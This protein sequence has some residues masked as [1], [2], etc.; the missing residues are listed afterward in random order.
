MAEPQKK[1]E[2]E[3]VFSEDYKVDVKDLSD[4]E[5]RETSSFISNRVL[6]A[7][8]GGKQERELAQASLRL[9]FKGRT[10]M[11]EVENFIGRYDVAR[12]FKKLKKSLK[13]NPYASAAFLEKL[14]GDPNWQNTLLAILEDNTFELLEINLDI[15]PDLWNFLKIQWGQPTKIKLFLDAR[16]HWQD[17]PNVFAR[18]AEILSD[19]SDFFE[20]YRNIPSSV[21]KGSAVIL[22]GLDKYPSEPNRWKTLYD[23]VNLIR[24]TSCL[25]ILLS[26]FDVDFLVDE[27]CYQECND[28][29]E[30]NRG[31]Q[32]AL[33]AKLRFSYIKLRYPEYAELTEDERFFSRFTY[34]RNFLASVKHMLYVFKVYK[35][36]GE[37][38]ETAD[39]RVYALTSS[40]GFSHVK[41]P[42]DFEAAEPWV[43]AFHKPES[44][45]TQEYERPMKA[46]IK[47]SK[48]DPTK[49]AHYLAVFVRLSKIW[50]GG[51]GALA[52]IHKLYPFYEMDLEQLDICAAWAEGFN[53]H[54]DNDLKISE[55][56]IRI[57]KSDTA[58]AAEY[59]R[60]L[61]RSG[62]SNH[63]P[64]G[65]YTKLRRLHEVYGDDVVK[66]TVCSNWCDEVEVNSDGKE[67]EKEAVQIFIALQEEGQEK[68]EKAWREFLTKL[69]ELNGELG[70]E[71]LK[72]LA[73]SCLVSIPGQSNFPALLERTQL[74]LTCVKKTAAL[75]SDAKQEACAKWLLDSVNF[76]TIV[77]D[78]TDVDFVAQ[79]LGRNGLNTQD[80]LE[81]YAESLKAN[82]ITRK[83]RNLVLEFL[84]HFRVVSPAIISGYKTAKAGGSEVVYLAQLNSVT[85]KMTGAEK[86]T[87][88][89]RNLPYYED[90]I[91]EVYKN[92][93]GHWTDYE[94]NKSCEDKEEDIAHYQYKP[95]YTIDLFSQSEIKV[96]P[97]E[98]LDK[99]KTDQLVKSVMEVSAELGSK[100]YEPSEMKKMVERKVD[101]RFDKV[102][103]VGGREKP[104]LDTLGVEEKLCVIVL[105]AMY[106]DNK[107][108]DKELKKLLISYEF[109]YFE[110]I[111]D[112]VQ[113]TNDRVS[114]APNKEYALLCELNT[115]FSD[116]IKEINKRIIQTGFKDPKVAQ[117]VPIYFEQLSRSEM[118]R[119]RQ[120]KVEGMQP[121]K[122]GLTGA[123]IKQ[124]T[125]T[126]E[127]KSGKKYTTEEVKK[128]IA[129]Y[130]KATG[131]LPENA[132][133]STKQRTKAVYGQLRSQ[134]EKTR[135]LAEFVTGQ[136]LDPRRIHLGE[137]N[138]AELMQAEQ[139]IS[140]GAYDPI[141]FEAYTVQRA[142]NLFTEEKDFLASELD[143]FISE[144]A[145][146]EVKEEGEEGKEAKE[147]KAPIIRKREVLNAYFAK[148]KETAN[149]RMVGG[150]CVSGDN[151]KKVGKDCMWN[152]K[153]YFELV[154]EDPETHRCMGVVLLHAFEEDGK[155]LAASFNP[156]STYL[157]KVDEAALF[158][159]L[160]ETLKDFAV[161]NKFTR[162]CSSQNKAIRT[163]RTGGIFE[164]TMDEEISKVGKVYQFPEAKKFSYSPSYEIQAMDTLWEAKK[165]A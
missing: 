137:M 102:L 124:I 30:K 158:K 54:D 42:N 67:S 149:A 104:K 61:Y 89:E 5:I 35:E 120:S 129:R 99:T 2:E 28:F 7:L 50:E 47:L 34:Y 154:L 31:E 164:R 151:P 38:K 87:T 159:G 49:A 40:R 60:L 88:A 163:N 140:G 4:R 63:L 15:L 150:V 76:N 21:E 128:L 3:D 138:V 43:T 84:Q 119:Q 11:S 17:N 56:Y 12:N 36:A 45:D 70:K 19:R 9:E 78:A 20:T 91:R 29:Y 6:S 145:V 26:D 90:L 161:E 8:L 68:Y 65:H 107:T 130:E 152:M 93:V 25:E 97:G 121:A 75:F 83:D 13:G 109:A 57:Y 74:M 126:L 143:K 94:N 24:L 155:T 62:H 160:L 157:Y 141:Q 144:T 77:S 156:S 81:G 118:S 103:K 92:N 115:F 116:R 46:Y 147:K 133:S 85:G 10:K 71:N 32:G 80:I 139:N 79:V 153:N 69:R 108:D 64:R 142:L 123:F 131:G 16:S 132:S 14:E 100:E 114:R 125:K 59:R 110:D 95:R 165:A 53:I 148:N 44:M 51:G 96:K 39:Q 18:L 117:V 41:D 136:D 72:E 52:S 98:A 101:E 1:P 86:L 48:E 105:D 22:Q 55:S 106:G 82:A 162:I 27:N 135:Q 73:H 37:D 127:G 112:Y 33:V 66:L 113:G 111:R 122:L 58:K 23:F 134:R 146:E